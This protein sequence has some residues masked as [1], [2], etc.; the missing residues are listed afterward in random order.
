LSGEEFSPG[1][2]EMIYLLWRDK[3][4]ERINNVLKNI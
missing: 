4:L 3:S 2:L 1:T